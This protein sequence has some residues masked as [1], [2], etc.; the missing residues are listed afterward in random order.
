MYYREAVEHFVSAL[1]MQRESRGPQGQT[2]AMSENIWGTLRMALSLL[3]RT[4]LYE[5]C[6]KRDLDRLKDI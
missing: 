4:D 6:E 3:G 5:A 2:T 1:N